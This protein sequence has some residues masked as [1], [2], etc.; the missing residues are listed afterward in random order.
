MA[1]YKTCYDLNEARTDSYKFSVLSLDDQ[2]LID[3]RNNIKIANRNTKL[4]YYKMLDKYGS[5]FALDRLGNN[6]VFK[7]L[8]VVVMARGKRAIHARREGLY[9][10]AYDSYLPLKYGEYFD[11]YVLNNREAEMMMR[12]ATQSGL[13]EKQLRAIDKVEREQWVQQ[14]AH[15][16]MLFQKYGIVTSYGRNGPT[17]KARD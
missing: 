1:Y 11:V 4:H 6:N 7:M 9:D 15:D 5:E 16:K 17:R 10:R 2:S 8:R 12:R 14:M 13:T 3:L